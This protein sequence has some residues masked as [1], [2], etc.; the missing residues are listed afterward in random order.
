MAGR[1]LR[2]GSISMRISETG[3]YL[4]EVMQEHLGLSQASV[5]ELLLR[6]EARRRGITIPG[7]GADMKKRQ[8][9]LAESI[10]FLT[11]RSP[12]EASWG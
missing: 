11:H 9:E 6:E 1:E 7:S 3:R 8:E 5:V 10:R 4:L 2:S 12:S